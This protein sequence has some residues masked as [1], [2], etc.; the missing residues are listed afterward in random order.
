MK[1]KYSRLSDKINMSIYYSFRHLKPGVEH[2]KKSAVNKKSYYILPD[3]N[4]YLCGTAYYAVC[5]CF[6]S[7]GG[8][9]ASPTGGSNKQ[10]DTDK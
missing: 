4:H 1:L 8:T 5:I 9:G 3:N 10:Y 6:H 2:E 7:R